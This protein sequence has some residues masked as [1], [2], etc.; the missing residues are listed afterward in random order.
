MN[1][2]VSHLYSESEW[3]ETFILRRLLVLLSGV[4]PADGAT[5]HISNISGSKSQHRP[6]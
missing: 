4:A 6:I 1:C 3:E 5:V 2:A